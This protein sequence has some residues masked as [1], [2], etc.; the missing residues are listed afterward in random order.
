MRDMWR[1]AMPRLVS[2]CPSARAGSTWLGSLTP[3]C[4]WPGVAR[5][6]LF[7]CAHV[8]HT[9]PCR[10]HPPIPSVLPGG[11]GYATP[12]EGAK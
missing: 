7:T 8:L 5:L 9:H 10:Q 12:R 11:C 6:C 4:P 3:S 2:P 1:P